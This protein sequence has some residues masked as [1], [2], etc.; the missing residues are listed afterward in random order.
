MNIKLQSK[1]S[2]KFASDVDA[3]YFI[4]ECITPTDCP[5]G[6]INFFC[7][8]NKCE[9]PNPKVLDGNKCVGRLPFQTKNMI[10][11]LE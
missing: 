3:L 1:I 4:L 7:N 10:N 8:D 6:G 9:C 2:F 11:E 5:Y